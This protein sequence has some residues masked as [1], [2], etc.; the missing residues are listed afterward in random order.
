MYIIYVWILCDLNDF[1]VEELVTSHFCLGCFRNTSAWPNEAR[2]ASEENTP[3]ITPLNGTVQWFKL[4]TSE[5]TNTSD[6]WWEESSFTRSCGKGP[7]NLNVTRRSEWDPK[8]LTVYLFVGYNQ[9]CTN[10]KGANCIRDYPRFSI[11]WQ[12]FASNPSTTNA[13]KAFMVKPSG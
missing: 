3:E 10:L 6:T 1:V 8:G 11:L 2:A 5:S 9:H 7:P 12:R 4:W 13:W